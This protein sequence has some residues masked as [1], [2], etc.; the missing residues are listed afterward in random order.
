MRNCYGS[1]CAGDVAPT[2]QKRPVLR[3]GVVPAE[4]SYNS[5][6]KREGGTGRV[7]C[8]CIEGMNC[9]V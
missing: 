2:R 9:L 4:R 3:H 1:V 7:Q 6:N 8:R 5:G